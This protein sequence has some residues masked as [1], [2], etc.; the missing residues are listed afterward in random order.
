MWDILDAYHEQ[1]I[2]EGA[3]LSRRAGQALADF[4]RPEVPHGLSAEEQ[5]VALVERVDKHPTANDARADMQA[6]LD[7]LILWPD[8]AE[9]YMWIANVIEG[10]DQAPY[11]MLPF[12]ALA[13]E[14]LH[15]RLGLG[16]PT[17]IGG[18][19]RDKPEAAMMIKALQGFGEALATLGQFREA[20]S[21]YV[22]ALGYDPDDR[23]HIRP[24]LALA[25]L[26]MADVDGADSTMAK[27]GETP[28]D[29]F[30]KAAV[31]YA[32]TE[33]TGRARQALLSARKANPYVTAFIT[34]KRNMPG[35]LTGDAQFDEA[36]YVCLAL[37]PA[38]RTVPGLQPW[39]KRESAPPGTA[40]KA[41][42]RR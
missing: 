36:Q 9:S 2:R 12:Y 10:R 15:R 42:G 5:A 7:A 31:A 4:A 14:A 18:R 28:L 16:G 23:E 30:A 25:L 20:V 26:C 40:A 37:G 32:L 38:L 33:G 17:D 22:E 24:R 29:L 39:I 1:S 41:K 11:L 6:L 8:C 34:G 3:E 21:K 27:A 13:L 35:M 19:L